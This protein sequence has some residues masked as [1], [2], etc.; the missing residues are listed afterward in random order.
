[1]ARIRDLGN[2]P[3]DE[4]RNML[5]EHDDPEDLPAI[6]GFSDESDLDDAPTEIDTSSDSSFDST[7]S[8]SSPVKARQ[9]RLLPRGQERQQAASPEPSSSHG[10]PEGI[11]SRGSHRIFRPSSDRPGVVADPVPGSSRS[12]PQGSLSR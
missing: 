10:R 8:E 1:M 4:I 12:G 6:A 3:E 7:C 9:I 5:F 2:L 11:F